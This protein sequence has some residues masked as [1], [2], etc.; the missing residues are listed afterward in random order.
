[1]LPE[2]ALA[3]VAL[4]PL[5]LV[6]EEV[7]EAPLPE[8]EPD[9]EVAVPLEAVSE[10]PALPVVEAPDPD[11]EVEVGPE[12]PV[13]LVES[14]LPVELVGVLVEAPEPVEAADAEEAML[15]EVAPAEAT[16]PEVAVVAEELLVGWGFGCKQPN[17]VRNRTHSQGGRVFIV[18]L[19]HQPDSRLK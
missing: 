2:E 9:P 6:P 18:I 19:L 8:V 3:V 12:E 15:E 14:P 17:P 1:V 5:E 4:P 16:D 13:E 10:V 11:V 7:P